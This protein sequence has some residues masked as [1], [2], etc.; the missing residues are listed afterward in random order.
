MPH[1]VSEEWR[2]T[3]SQTPT[4][5]ILSWDAAGSIELD[6]VVPTTTSKRNAFML[7]APFAGV[8]GW[9]NAC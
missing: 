9:L 2:H 6:A 5:T 7:S 1:Q 3:W 8:S 4:N